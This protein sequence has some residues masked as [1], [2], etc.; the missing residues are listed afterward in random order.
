MTAKKAFIFDLDGVIVDTA[1]YHYLAWKK[2]ADQLGINFTLEHNELLKG[3]SRVRSLDIIL[4]LGA[5]EASQE[6]KNKWLVQ[7]N[8]EYLS[9]LV[10]MDESEIL[11]GVFPVLKYLK[12]KGQ[13]IALGSASKNARPILEKTG[14][15]PYFD[16]IVDG[17]DVSNAKPDPEVFLRAAQLLDTA[18]EY[19]VVFEDSIAGIQAANSAKM[20]S[21]GIGDETTLHEAKYVFQDFTHID[22]HF[23]ETII[24]KR[25]N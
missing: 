5:V 8:E 25:V 14:I 1:K 17:N 24:N 18:P 11:P 9:Y 12:E 23:M 21:V 16:A 13:P 15:L 20:L 6:D 19:A 7:K 2:L 22:T 3:V 10:D 4:D